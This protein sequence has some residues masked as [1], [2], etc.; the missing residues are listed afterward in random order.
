MSLSPTY[1][2]QSLTLSPPE[3]EDDDGFSIADATIPQRGV[4]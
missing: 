4:E 2:K 1:S 3:F